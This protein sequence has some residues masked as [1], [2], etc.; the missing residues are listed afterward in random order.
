MNGSERSHVYMDGMN[1]KIIISATAFFLAVHGIAAAEDNNAAQRATAAA[2]LLAGI[3]PAGGDPMIDRL[4]ALDCS[5]E[6]RQ[7]MEAQ[8][9]QVRAR[10][11][12]MEQWRAHELRMVDG[13]TRTLI[14]PFSG[15]D[16]LNAYEMAPDHAR[17]IFFSLERPGRLHVVV[18][19]R[20]DGRRIRPRAVQLAYGHRVAAV[21]GHGDA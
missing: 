5:K 3:A 10:L 1:I 12:A 7:W 13:Q 9:N 2:Q 14:Y 11:S 20:E 4:A 21:H 18:A 8:W 17:Y 6:Q 16:F 15:P 19:V